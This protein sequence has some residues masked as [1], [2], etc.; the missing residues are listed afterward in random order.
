[1]KMEK[2]MKAV[3]SFEDEREIRILRGQCLNNSVT[4]LA[5]S[6][7]ADVKLI[8]SKGVF[9]FAEALFDEAIRRDYLNYG[10]FQD[11][12]TIDKG[13]GKVAEPPSSAVG[14]VPVTLTEKEGREMDASIAKEEGLVI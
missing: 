7:N 14:G 9:D 3:R 13:T 10:R 1:M 5:G 8:T 2:N 12:R 4:L 11:N 6:F